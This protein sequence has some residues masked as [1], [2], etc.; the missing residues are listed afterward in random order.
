[1]GD[2][3]RMPLLQVRIAQTMYDQLNR[4]TPLLQNHPNFRAGKVTL[5]DVVRLV[6]SLGIEVV[7]RDFVEK[8]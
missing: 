4:L 2:A 6:I 5:Q 7:T 1:M 3:Q 8:M